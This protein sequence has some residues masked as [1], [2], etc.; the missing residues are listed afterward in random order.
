MNMYEKYGRLTVI[1]IPVPVAY[2]TRT[3][4][5]V[6]VRCDCGTVKM[7]LYRDLIKGTTVSCGCYYREHLR[8]NARNNGKKSRHKNKYIIHGDTATLFDSKGH[9]CLIDAED[10]SVLEQYYFLLPRKNSYFVTCNKPRIY[11]HKLV[12]NCKDGQMVDHI[13]GN[14]LDNRKANL[15][16]C[17]AQQNSW[18]RKRSI[19]A[20]LTKS[21]KWKATIRIDGKN[22]SLGL[23]ETKE[24]A[25]AAKAQ[26][27]TMFYGEFSPC[28]R[29]AGDS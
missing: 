26:A 9:A 16:Y 4:L 6:L 10:I 28:N 17:T 19:G 23:F 1:G 27:L 8:E 13:N 12:M 15:R 14:K 5:K 11:I 29:Q 25:I 24:E 21:G 20:H 22:K 18:N 7:V 3:F 2:K